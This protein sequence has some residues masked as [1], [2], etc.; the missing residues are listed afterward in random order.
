MMTNLHTDHTAARKTP[1]DTVPGE[2]IIVGGDDLV[3][4]GGAQLSGLLRIYDEDSSEALEYRQILKERGFE[5]SRFKRPVLIRRRLN[6]LTPE[7]RM[8]FA[9]SIQE[10][11]SAASGTLDDTAYGPKIARLMEGAL[12]PSVAEALRLIAAD[13]RRLRLAAK[14]GASWLEATPALQAAVTA[15]AYAHAAER[16][17]GFLILEGVLVDT[18]FTETAFGFLRLMHAEAAL[19]N[20]SDTKTIAERLRAC[21]LVLETQD[22]SP[23]AS[24]S[25]PD[26]GSLTSAVPNQLAE[27]ASAVNAALT[28][29]WAERPYLHTARL[30]AMIDFDA[31][32]Q[33]AALNDLPAIRVMNRWLSRAQDDPSAAARTAVIAE[34]W[35]EEMV[36]VFQ[37]L[38]AT[39]EHH[40]VVIDQI[41]KAGRLAFDLEALAC[42]AGHRGRTFEAFPASL[43]AAFA[44]HGIDGEGWTRISAAADTGMVDPTRLDHDDMRRLSATIEQAPHP[45]IALDHEAFPLSTMI[46]SLIP[47]LVKAKNGP[48]APV[49]P[50]ALAMTAMAILALQVKLRTRKEPLLDLESPRAWVSAFL[51]SGAARLIG[52][53][54]AR[55]GDAVDGFANDENA[56]DLPRALAAFVQ[57]SATGSPLW[58]ARRGADRLLWEALQTARGRDVEAAYARMTG[59]YRAEAQLPHHRF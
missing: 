14:K 18:G 31:L 54:M 49:F 39:P 9:D 15:L 57:N 24:V 33:V 10:S 45:L 47:A 1:T 55:V 2:D 59:R 51:Q 48:F 16:P 22:S 53:L 32:R 4:A 42:L 43:Q 17:V 28:C 58:Y 23:A 12:P 44:R 50:G 25:G 37:R 11:R 29:G 38:L 7:E 40:Q 26:E 6:A 30:S 27:R 5:T 35:L 36:E 13:W 21:I 46:T 34:L 19:L 20:V 41:L 3:E 52:C 56:N 8:A